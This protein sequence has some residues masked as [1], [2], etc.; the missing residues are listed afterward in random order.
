LIPD[1]PDIHGMA[2]P[3]PAKVADLMAGLRLQLHHGMLARQNRGTVAVSIPHVFPRQP[4]TWQKRRELDA[5][6]SGLCPTTAVAGK[7]AGR[8]G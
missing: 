7:V 1:I 4:S 8:H 3:I 2:G 5:Q 6:S